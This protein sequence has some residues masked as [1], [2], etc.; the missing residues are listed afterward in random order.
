MNRAD[1][2]R[3][4]RESADR[5]G[6]GWRKNVGV[7]SVSIS[8][9]FCQNQKRTKITVRFDFVGFCMGSIRFFFFFF[10]T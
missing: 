5:F 6:W 3:H 4:R 10:V 8:L 7:G 1:R 2:V 9:V